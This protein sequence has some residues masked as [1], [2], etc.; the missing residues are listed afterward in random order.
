MTEQ[1]P[2]PLPA[3]E[4]LGREDYLVTEA[5]APVLA[6]LDGWRGWPGA[7]A[8]LIGAPGAGKSHLARVWAA[9]SG[10]LVV[11]AA[12]VTEEAAP[13]LAAGP[14]AVEDLDRAPR[15][16]TALFHLH[17]L[18]AQAGAPLLMTARGAPGIWAGALPDLAS[19][20]A[21]ALAIPLPPPDDALLAALAAKQFADRGVAPDP[22]V[23][24]WLTTHTERS[25]EAIRAAVARLDAAA[26][27]AKRPIT[28][29][30]A[31]ET[32]R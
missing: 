9:S 15:A 32:L 12:E 2:L 20:A 1:L 11:P 30:L 31:R 7:K 13:R 21:Q 4:A 18:M 16:G 23:L 26:L 29:P 24:A 19:R 25:A 10:A 17:N 14:L 6:A 8:L 5:T 27:A 22:R 28:V 3:R